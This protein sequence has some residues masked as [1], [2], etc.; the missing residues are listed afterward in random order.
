MSDA[1]DWVASFAAISEFLIFIL[2]DEVV[3]KSE[4]SLHSLIPP[5]FTPIAFM[6]IS[7]AAQRSQIPRDR[8]FFPWEIGLGRFTWVWPHF[9]ISFAANPISFFK[10]KCSAIA[11]RVP[12]VRIN[13]RDLQ[14]QLNQSRFARRNPH[15][16]WRRPG[17]AK[18]C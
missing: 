1:K 13:S 10:A 14:R 7:S 8:T 2:W 6:V 11:P 4:S 17:R 15:P 3:C 12:E 18:T 16:Q 5:C 9:K